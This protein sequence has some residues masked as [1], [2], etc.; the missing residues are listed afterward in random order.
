M[1]INSIN[2]QFPIGNSTL[3]AGKGDTSSALKSRQSGF[4][5]STN[6]D[7][8]QAP[9]QQNSLTDKSFVKQQ[10]ET[11]LTSFPPYFPAGSP[12]RIDL[13]KGVKGVQ[14][15]IKNSTLPAAVKDRLTGQKL[16]DSATDQEISTALKGV[17]QYVGNHNQSSS[18]LTNNSKSVEIVSIKV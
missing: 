7:S 12:Q 6:A 13:I 8:P 16:T 3:P 5:D 2:I 9:L 18:K 4:V 14:D 15:E 17:Q 11:I 10:I 1:E